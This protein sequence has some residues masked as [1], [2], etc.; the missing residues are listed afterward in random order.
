MLDEML[1]K[2]VW[3]GPDLVYREPVTA[4]WF[5][6]SLLGLVLVALVGHLFVLSRGKPFEVKESS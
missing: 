5:P 6:I 2:S 4:L 3:A 1:A